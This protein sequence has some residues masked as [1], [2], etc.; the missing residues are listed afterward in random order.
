MEE[1]PTETTKVPPI[2]DEEE[3]EIEQKMI[4]II[5]QMPK[6]VQARFKV[7]K[8]L[9]DKRSKLSDK[10][11]EEVKAIEKK[12]EDRRKPLY[13]DRQKIVE[14]QI[15]EFATHKEK[16]D[17]THKKLEEYCAT[18]VTKTE[19]GEDKAKKE[20][21]KK[22]E[23]DHL[24]T[25]D[26]I[27]DFWFKAIKNNQMIFELV[28]E[29]DEEILKHLKCLTTEKTMNPKTLTVKFVFGENENFDEKELLLK[30]YYRGDEDD[31]EKIEGTIITWKEGKDPT[32]K[33]V[34]KK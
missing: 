5:A 34:K 12:F 25:V 17:E 31:V 16:F 10:F 9:S 11:E 13:D 1:P 18:I 28:K 33:K 21:L 15:K 32:K 4:K 29:K 23:V 30:V 6:E 2:I 26:G 3:K 24:K 19:D 20:E 8:I 27:P 22:V 7:L 14:G